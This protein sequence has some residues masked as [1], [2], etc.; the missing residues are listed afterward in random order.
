MLR[1]AT[2]YL[3]YLYRSKNKHGVHSPFVY[4]LLTKGLRS[5]RG[6]SMQIALEY[7]NSLFEDH[8]AI[9]VTDFGAGS[10]VFRSEERRVSEIAKNAGIS[11]RRGGVLY[12]LVKYLQPRS[13]LEIGTSLGLSTSYMAAA[14]PD[15]S[16]ITLE[17]CPETAGIAISNFKKF[18]LDNI[19]VQVG[20]F[21]NTLPKVLKD[22][23]FDLVFM[24][25]NHQKE[26]TLNYF[27][28]CLDSIHENSLIILDDIHW[29][30]GMDEAWQEI[31]RHPKVTISIDT[32]QWGLVFFRKGQAR[33]HFVLRL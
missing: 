17:G 4:D 13:I 32:F 2:A 25:G 24:D 26:A 22:K 21:A 28:I 31:C 5:H 12:N 8:S 10:R 15:A 1:S 23:T 19:D 3:R 18:G 29:S 27:E 7:R 30:R 14:K 33:Q 6:E 20:E 9:R 16:I 11:R